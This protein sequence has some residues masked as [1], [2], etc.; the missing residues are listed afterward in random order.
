MLWDPSGTLT[1]VSV[2]YDRDIFCGGQVHL[3][4]GR[5]MVIGGVVFQ[6]AGSQVGVVETDFFDV[7]TETWS[8][9]PKHE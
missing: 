5:L 8:P 2:P 3:A 7:T 9:G 4:D 1:D 6:H